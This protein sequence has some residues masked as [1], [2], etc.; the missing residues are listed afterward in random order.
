MEDDISGAIEG[1]E[2]VVKMDTEKGEW[3]FKALKKLIQLYFQK[4][5][6]KKVPINKNN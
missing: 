5:D 6:L 1:F 3:A 4:S 2:E